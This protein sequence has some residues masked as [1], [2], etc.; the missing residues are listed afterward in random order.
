MENPF[1]PESWARYSIKCMLMD[2]GGAIVRTDGNFWSPESTDDLIPKVMD[3]YGAK[4]GDIL[5]GQGRE[6]FLTL[7]FDLWEEA[8]GKL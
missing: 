3:L 1:K 6:S 5:D 7:C 2:S 4:Y 8:H